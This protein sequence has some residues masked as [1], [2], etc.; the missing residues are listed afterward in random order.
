MTYLGEHLY[1]CAV[2]PFYWH[3]VQVV[4]VS[5][6]GPNA[7]GHTMLRAGNYYFHI[8][9]RQNL[10]WFLDE[11]GFKRYLRENDKN[12][13]WRFPVTLPKPEAAQ[14]KLEELMANRW[15]WWGLWNNCATFVETV[16]TAGGANIASIGNCPALGWR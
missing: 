9:G 6:W 8:D 16:M 5:G 3:Q 1:T 11:A 15:K 10:P 12:E 7:C 13:L 2:I 4:I 14:R